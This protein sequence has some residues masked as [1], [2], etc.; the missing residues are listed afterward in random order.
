MLVIWSPPLAIGARFKPALLLKAG[1]QCSG[2]TDRL[3]IC[4][5][6]V[7]DMC[8]ARAVHLR[9]ALDAGMPKN[10]VTVLQLAGI[11]VAVS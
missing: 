11:A 1:A 7:N 3:V 4:Q 10:I 8:S 2:G 5:L 6:S 9:V